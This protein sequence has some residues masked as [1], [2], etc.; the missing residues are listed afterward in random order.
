[1]SLWHPAQYDLTSARCS[2]ALGALVCA[3]ADAA[4]TNQTIRAVFSIQGIPFCFSSIITRQTMA[5]G[6]IPRGIATTLT[7]REAA[8][9]TQY[10]Q[11]PNWG[12]RIGINFQW[13][14]ARPGSIV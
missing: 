4:Q 12:Q 7:Y 6:A 5:H 3:H 14:A 9:K 11:A 10:S 2:A 8:R 13:V 1:L